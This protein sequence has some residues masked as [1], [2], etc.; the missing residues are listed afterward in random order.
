MCFYAI[1]KIFSYRIKNSQQVLTSD[2]CC[3][4]ISKYARRTVKASR[5]HSHPIAMRLIGV[6]IFLFLMQFCTGRDFWEWMKNVHFF[7]FIL[8]EGKSH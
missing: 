2:T 8:M 5:V 4:N 3:D 6:H 1:G 7:Y